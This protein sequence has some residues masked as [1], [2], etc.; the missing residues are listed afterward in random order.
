MVERGL[1]ASFDHCA[2]FACFVVRRAGL[3]CVLGQRQGWVVGGHELTVELA[4]D[5]AARNILFV[6]DGWPSSPDLRLRKSLCLAEV[7]AITTT[8]E[9]R[10]YRGPEL[11]RFKAMALVE[12]GI[13]PAPD[14][15]LPPLPDDA[16]A[17]AVVTW[18]L[19]GEVARI[20]VVTGDRGPM[21]LVAPWLASLNGTSVDVIRAGKRWL[22]QHG[23][24]GRT[25]E[26]PGRFGKHTILWKIAEDGP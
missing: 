26:A 18:D 13:V 23:R 21:P 7:F 24:I 3:V 14:L 9:V 6:R 19:I 20:R 11:A 22:E 10:D 25:G 5:K 16:P 12:A 1:L 4:L 15:T 17:A 2:D 8:G